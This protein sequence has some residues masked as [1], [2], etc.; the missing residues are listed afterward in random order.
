MVKRSNYFVIMKAFVNWL[1]FCN[2][3][4]TNVEILKDCLRE[5]TFWQLFMN[6][7]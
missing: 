5:I 2:S 1:H 4:K 3:G 6:N 7:N